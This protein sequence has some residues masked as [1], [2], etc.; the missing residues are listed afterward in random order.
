M[1]RDIQRRVWPLAAIA[2]ASAA[3]WFLDV[4]ATAQQQPRALPTFVVDASWPKVPDRY[5]LGDISSIAIDAQDNAYVL[6]RP[7]T[8]KG[9]D[10]A[11]AA[12]P[13][14]VFDPA[15]NFI[16]GWGGEGASYEWPQREHGIH[17]DH[18]GFAWI[19]GNQCPTSGTAGLKPVA[20]DQLL[21]F[22]LDGKFVLQIV[23]HRV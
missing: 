14:M 8:L 17:I 15:G 9:E 1:T 19:G 6:H 3:V 18:K 16:K 10:A 4:P 5:K 23:L 12:P 7:R 22:T 2:A 11:K 13:V 21:K 20:D